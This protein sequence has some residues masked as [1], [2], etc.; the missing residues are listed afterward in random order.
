MAFQELYAEGNLKDCYVTTS[1][2]KRF[3]IKKKYFNVYICLEHLIFVLWTVQ[4]NYKNTYMND[5]QKVSR[6]TRIITFTLELL[7]ALIHATVAVIAIPP[8]IS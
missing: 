5:L 3:L 8:E 4:L 1:T 2:I 7:N 6:P